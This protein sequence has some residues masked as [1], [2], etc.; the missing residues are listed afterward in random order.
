MENITQLKAMT[1]AHSPSIWLC[2][3][4]GL[5]DDVHRLMNGMFIFIVF[6]KFF[7]MNLTKQHGLNRTRSY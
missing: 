2:V 4:E 3:Q 7:L 6:L 1:E 5:I